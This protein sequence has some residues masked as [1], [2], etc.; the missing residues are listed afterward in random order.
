M[1]LVRTVLSSLLVALLATV[2]LGLAPQQ[3]TA[4]SGSTARQAARVSTV[5]AS[6]ESE[7]LR[8]TNRERQARGLRPLAP[9]YC[10]ERV[11]GRWAWKMAAR[12]M[13]KHQKV[14]RIARACRTGYVGENIAMGGGLSAARVVSLWMHS[15]GHRRNILNPKYGH[16]G[17]GAYRSA[18]GTYVVQDFSR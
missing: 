18:G 14:R 4:A 3:A 17:V 9:S 12:R 1:S 15:A 11:A 5:S 10:T 16:L 8:L 13:F 7:V 6:F 2:G